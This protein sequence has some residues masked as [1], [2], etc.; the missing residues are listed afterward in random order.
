MKS[1][2]GRLAS[3]TL[4]ACGLMSHPGANSQSVSRHYQVRDGSHRKEPV[5]LAGH[6]QYVEVPTCR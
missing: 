4:V 5:E 1:Y 3:Y 2:L 6:D